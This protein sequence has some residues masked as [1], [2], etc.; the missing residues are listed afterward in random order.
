[1]EA[2]VYALEAEREEHHW[3]FVGRRRLFAKELRRAGIL[4]DAR[5]LDIG[6]SSGAN[7]RMLRDLGFSRVTGLDNNDEAIRICAE[8]GLGHVQKGDI[9]SMPFGDG[10]FDL[11]LATDVLEHVDDDAGSVAEISRVLASGGRAL[12]TAP[13]FQSLWGLQDRQSL[14]KRRYRLRPLLQLLQSRGL[15]IERSYYFNY[16]LFAPIW[17]ARRVIDLFGFGLQSEAQ[18]NSALLNRVMSAVFA[19]DLRTAPVIR[20]P[21]GVSILVMLKR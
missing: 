15:R 20:V 13:A 14:H 12:I 3:W 18:V 4:T 16:L 5:V 17:L 1:M 8:K 6:T 10:S 2:A 21:F 11:V 9:C 7:L 19:V